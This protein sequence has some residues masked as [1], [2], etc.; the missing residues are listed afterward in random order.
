MMQ[1]RQFYNL[2]R[3]QAMTYKFINE[4]IINKPKPTL[5]KL[6]PIKEQQPKETPSYL[7]ENNLCY[8]FEIKIN[9]YVQE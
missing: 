8:I 2:R 3:I 6:T 1:S 7:K 5:I 4:I 9:C